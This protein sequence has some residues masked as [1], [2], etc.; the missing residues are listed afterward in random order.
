MEHNV[1]DG[2]T[3]VFLVVNTT[4]YNAD[5]RWAVTMSSIDDLKDLGFDAVERERI[6]GLNV[7]GILNDFDFYGVIVIRVA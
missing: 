5:C 6:D 1:I 4:D 3:R 7:G 2:D